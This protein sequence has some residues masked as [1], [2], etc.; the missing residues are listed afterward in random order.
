MTELWESV[1]ADKQMV[2]GPE[3]CRSAVFAR[4]YFA[5]TGAKEILVPGIGYGRNAR[6]FLEHG[7]SVTGIEIS[8]TA[9][10]L[11]RTQMGLDIPI[12]HGSVA[13]MPYDARLYDGVFAYGLLYLL[14]PPARAKLLQDCHRQLRK[15]G[16][17]IFTVISKQ[18]PM[19][20]RGPK[21]GDDWY[22]VH[23]GVTMFFYDAE[24]IRRELGPHGELELSEID[25]PTPGGGT[26]PFINVVCRKG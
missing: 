14:A 6:P 4:D 1:F 18:A 25:E 22:E 19:F 24:S 7:M 21:L 26:F 10:G 9:I 23:P 17:M 8:G 15:G 20:G 3:P 5:R 16:A 11:A 12:H 2:W 13:D